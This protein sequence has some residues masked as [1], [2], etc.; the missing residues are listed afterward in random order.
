MN[1]VKQRH[2]ES[3]GDEHAIVKL[4]AGERAIVAGNSRGINMTDEDVS[5]VFLHI[6]PYHVPALP[7]PSP[8]DLLFI[9]SLKQRSSFLL[10]PRF[11]RFYRFSTIAN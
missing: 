2:Y 6:H 5:K 11:D 3:W 10:E 9:R 4:V 8:K 7:G 1:E